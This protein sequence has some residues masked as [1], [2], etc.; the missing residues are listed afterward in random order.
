MKWMCII[1][2]LCALALSVLPQAATAEER[3]GLGCEEGK[4]CISY[5]FSKCEDK[6]DAINYD[7]D[8]NLRTPQ[9]RAARQRAA[10]EAAAKR[11]AED[12]AKAAFEARVAAQTE[13]MGSHRHAEARKF[14]EMQDRAMKAAGRPPEMPKDCKLEHK[15]G[16]IGTGQF[17]RKQDALAQLQRNEGRQHCPGG[18]Y[19]I[20]SAPECV[21]RTYGL[22]VAQKRHLI[23]AGIKVEDAEPEV[24]W[25]CSADYR[26]NQSQMLC[27][28]GSAPGSRQ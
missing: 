4:A 13:K 26:C 3:Y 12:A 11:A 20:V 17:P 27:T 5:S 16:R 8:G 7:C 10:D 28:A 18:A 19:S 6:G 25:G 9:D 2:Q 21:S 22:T 24:K 14:I 15:T 23:A 1:A